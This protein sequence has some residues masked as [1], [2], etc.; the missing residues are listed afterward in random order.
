MAL[1]KNTFRIHF[2]VLMVSMMSF[3]GKLLGMDSLVVTSE[4]AHIRAQ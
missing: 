4:G 2:L 1:N 3:T